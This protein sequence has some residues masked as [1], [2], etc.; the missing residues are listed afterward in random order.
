MT[1][2]ARATSGNLRSPRPTHA[3]T[4]HAPSGVLFAAMR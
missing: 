4:A 1:D 3:L 2:S